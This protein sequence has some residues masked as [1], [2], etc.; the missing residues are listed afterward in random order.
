MPLKSCDLGDWGLRR[1]KENRVEKTYLFSALPSHLEIKHNST[2]K[3]TTHV[4]C[5]TAI[6]LK[7]FFEHA[8]GTM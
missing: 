6:R 2:L 8:F 4:A 7:L 1:G 3:I 5:P